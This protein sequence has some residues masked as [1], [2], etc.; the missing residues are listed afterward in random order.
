MENDK[1]TPSP[2]TLA[3]ATAFF[4]ELE[5]A[6]ETSF[7]DMWE[8]EL[9]NTDAPRRAGSVIANAYM[10]SAARFA[11]F[12][13]Q[14]AG[15]QPDLDQWKKFALEQFGRALEDYARAEQETAKPGS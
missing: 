13:A 2:R 10:R 8:S 12:G 6:A 11:V 3:L 4:T 14:C 9:E 7:F 5:K 1:F 15:V